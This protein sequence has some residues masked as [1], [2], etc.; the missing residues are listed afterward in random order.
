MRNLYLRLR[1]LR[2]PAGAVLL[3]LAAV[4]LATGVFTGGMALAM[5]WTVALFL[6][7]FLLLGL[8]RRLLCPGTPALGMAHAVLAQAMAGRWVLWVAAFLLAVLLILA[9]GV[10]TKERLDYTERFFLEWSQ[11]AIEVTLGLFT[12]ALAALSVSSEYAGKQIHANLSKPVGRFAYIGGKWLGLMAINTVLVAVCGTAIY[13]YTGVIEAHWVAQSGQSAEAQAADRQT[14]HRE[15]LTARFAVTPAMENPAM[16]SGYFLERVETLVQSGGL[17]N[18]GAV[19][20]RLEAAKAAAAPPAPETFKQLLSRRNYANCMELALGKWYTLGLPDERGLAT[21]PSQVYVFSGL[22]AARDRAQAAQT[23][24]VAELAQMGLAPEQARAFIPVLLMQTNICPK[25]V[26]EWGLKAY[27]DPAKKARLETLRIALQADRLQLTL[28]PDAGGQTPREGMV[29]LRVTANGV[30]VTPLELAR[31]LALVKN[32]VPPVMMATGSR[33]LP[34]GQPTSLEIPCERVD[35]QGRLAIRLTRVLVN[36]RPQPTISFNVADGIKLY[37]YAGPFA[38][39][40]GA[41]MAVMLVKIG[42]LAMLGLVC[43]CLL[44]FPVA[45]LTAIGVYAMAACAGGLRDSFGDFVT[46]GHKPTAGL[47]FYLMWF[48]AIVRIGMSL[49]LKLSPDFESYDTRTRIVDGVAIS[50]AMLAQ[51]A[52]ILGG[53][54]TGGAALAGWLLFERREIARVIV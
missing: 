1:W 22:F 6:G 23:K 26:I 20:E 30:P 14:T 16:L 34:V 37:G 19:G 9:L 41:A 13:A 15:V 25:P 48:K 45:C 10:D 46:L 5:V 36:G 53:L 52:G 38:L 7:L 8:A 40:L 47:D 28:K 43:G 21:E 18:A 33:L 44:S 12:L 32:G 49:L 50:W 35:K 2:L 51:C 39:N 3:A 42:F 11:L 27:A 29:E 31:R 17:D 24:A 4:L 54:W